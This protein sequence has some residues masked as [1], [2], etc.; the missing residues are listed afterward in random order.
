MTAAQQ[1]QCEENRRK[2]LEIEEVRWRNNYLPTDNSGTG[3]DV[4]RKQAQSTGKEK[5]TSGHHT[6]N[7][8][9]WKGSFLQKIVD[10]DPPTCWSVNLGEL[11]VTS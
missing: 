7:T 8:V 11:L 10:P 1:T 5:D 3:S 4:Q 9:Y 6:K 2:V